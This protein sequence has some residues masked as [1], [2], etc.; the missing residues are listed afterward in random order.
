MSQPVE[1]KLLQ[2]TRQFCHFKAKLLLRWLGVL[3]LTR[4]FRRNS[5]NSFNFYFYPLHHLPSYRCESI[6]IWTIRDVLLG[7]PTTGNKTILNIFWSKRGGKDVIDIRKC[8]IEKNSLTPSEALKG[9][10]LWLLIVCLCLF[11]SLMG[12]SLERNR[13]RQN[14]W[15]AASNIPSISNKNI[16][17]T[18][19][20]LLIWKYNYVRKYTHT[21]WGAP[22]YDFI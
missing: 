17:T 3:R 11:R 20:F 16:K 7:I 21:H 18:A 12:R 10:R 22:Q 13:L 19:K 8:H 5:G 15:G 4:I 2:S 1:V 14:H 6:I 9:G